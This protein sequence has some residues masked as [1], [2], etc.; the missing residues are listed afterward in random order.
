MTEIFL[1]RLVLTVI[2]VG[3][4]SYIDRA[5]RNITFASCL[6]GGIAFTVSEALSPIY[7]SGFIMYFISAVIV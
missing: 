2:G 5:R 7:G 3:L 1:Y 4:F 6:C